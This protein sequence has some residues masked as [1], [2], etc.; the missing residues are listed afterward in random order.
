MKRT[1]K[2]L[3]AGLASLFLA[4]APA[5]AQEYPVS[6]IT[7][8]V[9]FSAGGNVDIL[10]RQVA[11]ILSRHLGGATV[12][13][14][15]RPGAAGS[16]MNQ[17]LANADPDG[18]TLGMLSGPGFLTVLFGN[19]LSYNADSFDYIGTFTDEAY[20]I[21]VGT[22]TPYMTLED[23]VSAAREAPGTITIGG[24][25]LGGAPHLALKLLESAADIEFNFIPGGGASEMRNQVMGGHIDGGVTSL[26]VGVPMDEENQ[27]RLLAVFSPE[28]V[29]VGPDYPTARE[30]GYDVVWSAMR[31]LAGPSNL[32]QD[33]RDA[34]AAAVQEVNA[35]PDHI[36]QAAE[37]NMMTFYADG[38]TF[39][40]IAQTQQIL[41]EDIWAQEP[42]I[43]N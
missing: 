40:S 2:M 1:I 43:E 34:L 29:N 5:S 15:N 18:Y 24:A 32:P 20:S 16:I 19:E 11:P 41:L 26:S 38:E 22:D 8:L 27:G 33:I 14:I 13:V 17:E 6:T 39:Q 28:R 42:W 7:L 3:A 25:G 35:D 9:G 30:Q 4:A 21:V 37:R 10:A 36:S 31:G 12:A 23:L